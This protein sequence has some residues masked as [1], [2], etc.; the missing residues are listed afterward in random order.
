MKGAPVAA[1]SGASPHQPVC[2][3]FSLNGGPSSRNF[4]SLKHPVRELW[5]QQFDWGDFQRMRQLVQRDDSRIATAAFEA[6]DILLREARG[7]GEF[8]L[9]HAALDASRAHIA[10]DEFAHVHAQFIGCP[11]GSGLS[12]IVCIFLPLIPS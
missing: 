5:R 9:G 3:F 10:A 1:V 4:K 8:F 12:T 2:D 11:G 7:F 6:G